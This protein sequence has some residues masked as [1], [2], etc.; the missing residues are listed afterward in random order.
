[1]D[2][3]KFIV[4]RLLL[5]LLTMFLVSV[6]VF[7]ITTAA[8]G[9]VA[10]NVLGIQITKEQEASFL[11]QNGLD[12]PAYARYLYWLFGTDWRARGKVGL[13][14][15]EI[16]T[17]DGF[18]E[19]WA[20]GEDGTLLRWKLEGENLIVNKRQPDG[21]QV[22]SEDNG[23]WQ[24]KDPGSEAARLEEYRAKLMSNPQVAEADRQAIL[25]PLDQILEMLHEA[26][27]S[28]ESQT[29]LLASLAQPEADLD[30]LRNPD[31][32]KEK[33]DL[34]K[35]A[36]EMAS[37]DSLIQ[38]I[39]VYQTLASPTAGDFKA[40][41][42]QFMAGQLNRSIFKMKGLDP[43][44]ASELQ[45]AY[46]SLKADDAKAAQTS[47]A[48]VIPSLNRMTGNFGSFT[49][50]LDQGD[51]QLA[52]TVLRDLGDPAK[53]PFDD[54]QLMVAPETLKVAG[55]ALG[56]ANPDL[57][58]AIDQSV[59]SLEAGNLVD[60]RKSLVQAAELL[61]VMGQTIARNDA[62]G[63]AKVGRVFWG[64]DTQNHA[65][66]WE[67]GS[68][69]EIWVFIQ[70]TG[71]KAFIGGPV[72]YIPLQSGLLR[73]DPGVSLRTGRPVGDLLFIRLRNSLVLAGTA[74][75]IVMP[76]ALILGIIAGLKEGKPVDR[77]LSIG[78]MMFSVTPEFAT[79][80]F[81]IL[82]FAFWLK[83][84][85]GATVFG[86]K[87]PWTRPDMLILPVMTLTLVEL[88]YVM[89]I[90]RASMVEVMKAPYIRTAFLKGLPYRQVVMK[91]AVRNALMAPI[92]V[93]MLHVNWLLGGI[94][95]VE[96]IFGYPGLGSYLLESA[97]FKDFNA[98]EA[99]AMILV[100]VAVTTQLLADIVYT[101]INPRIRYA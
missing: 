72:E 17:P 65:V 60:A 51:Y 96:V 48:S 78:G 85:P 26:V 45:K 25:Q 54:A 91:H 74:F 77:I 94:V 71:W 12:K 6:A 18:R 38:A 92:T 34:Q 99:G 10:R 57:G 75:I 80:I 88:G 15:R 19:W 56:E 47:L 43:A 16:T 84:V 13:P 50:A 39:A 1:M 7:A 97:L 40:S 68:G 4:R 22:E 20:V 21:T 49:E 61:G 8:P 93:I 36:A 82:I 28:G 5:M 33:Q 42:L 70:G 14:V 41:E 76:L 46:E 52:A 101:F 37:N 55:S 83:L 58:K 59:V 11:A 87:A 79:G 89:R 35:A 81:L 69:K 98:I 9:N 90:T 100:L 63:L 30:A 53:T 29:A 2:M 3:A 31:A 64:I 24:V 32:A 73:G 44:I 86:E 95:V 27:N 67:T 66:R 23:R 62:A